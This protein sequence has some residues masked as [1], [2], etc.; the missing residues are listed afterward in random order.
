MIFLNQNT[1]DKIC[2]LFFSIYPKVKTITL[3]KD[4]DGAFILSFWK[5]TDIE[6]R[7]GACFSST[8]DSPFSYFYASSRS[9]LV[10]TL[11]LNEIDTVAVDSDFESNVL[12]PGRAISKR[13]R[14]KLENKID[15]TANQNQIQWFAKMFSSVFSN[16]YKIKFMLWS[17]LRLYVSEQR[18]VNVVFRGCGF[19]TP[20]H[21]EFFTLGR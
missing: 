5:K 16:V 7:Q 6:Y 2:F 12:F 19:R 4:E 21:D 9:G 11:K 10:T 8:N 1:F 20:I 13:N 17:S 18:Y 3:H 14:F 15:Y